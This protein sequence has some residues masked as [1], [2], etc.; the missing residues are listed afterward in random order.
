MDRF[1]HFPLTPKTPLARGKV[2]ERWQ[3]TLGQSRLAVEGDMSCRERRSTEKLARSLSSTGPPRLLTARVI[4]WR[5]EPPNLRD[6]R[7][8][9]SYD[10]LSRAEARSKRGKSTCGVYLLDSEQP[11]RRTLR[12]A[13]ST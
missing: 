11:R 10:C 9:F 13:W 1:G 2:R 8:R 12:P 5:A 7:D 6:L 4:G 3:G